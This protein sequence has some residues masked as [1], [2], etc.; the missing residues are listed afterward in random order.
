VEHGQPRALQHGGIFHRI[1]RRRGDE[2]HALVDH[3]SPT[4]TLPPPSPTPA[5][6]ELLIVT[7]GG[8]SLFLMN[9]SSQPFPL[10][11]LFLGE[12]DEGVNGTEW[13]V[14]QLQ[15][16]DCVTIWR[17]NGRPEAPDIECEVVGARLTRRGNQ[18]FWNNDFEVLY[19][20]EE[21]GSCEEDDEEC[22]ITFSP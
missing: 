8:E 17:G 1:A 10:G 20:D 7:N 6:Y 2:L 18:I 14:N 22:L 3:E 4:P 19:N 11:P 13:E 15:P 21:I 9:R 12:D 5:D 16:G